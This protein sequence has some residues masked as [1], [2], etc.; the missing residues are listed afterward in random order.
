M[1]H[2]FLSFLF[3][4]LNLIPILEATTRNPVV[5]VDV[6]S[7]TSPLTSSIISTPLLPRK[8]STSLPPPLP[9][10]NIPFIFTIPSPQIQTHILTYSSSLA[11][12]FPTSPMIITP[13]SVEIL[14]SS[15]QPDPLVTP[16]HETISTS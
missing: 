3:Y 2:D 4:E 14:V 15:S 12:I 9:Q 7:P 16:Q 6:P 1:I 8:T 13:I 11:P 5:L 10:I